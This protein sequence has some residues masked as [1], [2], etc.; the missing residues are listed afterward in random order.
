M[1][2]IVSMTVALV[3]L[4]L[5]ACTK[6]PV[7]D[8]LVFAP[9]ASE[10]TKETAASESKT[11]EK[12]KVV[13]PPLLVKVDE[14]TISVQGEEVGVLNG[15]EVSSSSILDAAAPALISKEDKLF[16]VKTPAVPEAAV[17]E[18]ITTPSAIKLEIEAEKNVEIMIVSTSDIESET[19]CVALKGAEAGKLI[20]ADSAECWG[21]SETIA[22][23]LQ[24]E[25]KS[26]LVSVSIV[27]TET[28]AGLED[29]PVLTLQTR[30]VSE[31]KGKDDASPEVALLL[32]EEPIES[33]LIA[34]S[35]PVVLTESMEKDVEDVLADE[36][37]SSD[38][39][40]KVTFIKERLKKSKIRITER[41]KKHEELKRERKDLREKRKLDRVKIAKEK[42]SE[43]K[44]CKKKKLEKCDER[45]KAV[46]EL[47][48]V[49]VKQTREIAELKDQLEMTK[50][51]V[52]EEVKEIKTQH[53]EVKA[54][55]KKAKQ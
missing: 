16:M 54:M 38:D 22:P 6:K 14:D 36:T 21:K 2:S 7:T 1:K 23:V 17:L 12:A 52:L 29:A 40:D 18:A 53:A 33:I 51:E 31:P 4:H 48:E 9:K 42:N 13:T 45:S 27:A 20:A 30:V 5:N 19:Q 24:P 28:L 35:L 37:L 26:G 44:Q 39:R 25:V 41:K 15:T 43:Q 50:S 49:E 46:K 8:D 11:P 55:K 3:I 32:V 34:E 10:S 47:A